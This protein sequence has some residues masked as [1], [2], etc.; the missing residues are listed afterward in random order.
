[1]EIEG[2]R[3]DE[4]R[5]TQIKENRRDGNGKGRKIKFEKVV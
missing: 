5:E 2:I 1:M 3:G 4:V